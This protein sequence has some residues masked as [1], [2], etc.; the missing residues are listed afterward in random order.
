MSLRNQNAATAHLLRPHL[1]LPQ[2]Q[3]SCANLLCIGIVCTSANISATFRIEM[4]KLLRERVFRRQ[5]REI[6][7]RGV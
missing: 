5:R 7:V 2:A 3:S 6:R 4:A 1:Q